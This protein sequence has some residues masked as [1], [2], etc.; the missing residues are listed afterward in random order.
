MKK[1]VGKVTVEEKDEILSLYERRNSLTE[2]AGSLT[3]DNEELYDKMVKDL[4][5]TGTKF[6]NWW[7]RMAEKYQWE[8]VE[9]GN[10][11]IDFTTCEITLVTPQ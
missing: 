7:D 1:L 10:W 6:Q 5:E 8:G 9:G 2:L 4:G 11:E 3:V